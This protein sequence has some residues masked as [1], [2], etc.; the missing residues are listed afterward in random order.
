MERIS[1]TRVFRNAF[2]RAYGVALYFRSTKE[3]R[4]LVSLPCSKNR[5][6]SIKWVTPSRLELL[7]ALVGAWLL[8]YFS[9]VTGYD[10]ARST[11]W[12]D[13][14]VALSWIRSAPNRWKMFV[15]NRITA[16]E[17]RNSPT[18]CRH[19]PGRENPADHLSRGI[20]CS[21]ILLL[22]IWWQWPQWLGKQEGCWPSGN[23]ATT[24]SL[25]EG[26][27]RYPRHVLR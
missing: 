5:L 7:A 23:F 12:T 18:Q 26:K 13:T 20:L 14:T 4:T 1:Q 2:E 3:E 22:D 9:E 8:S 16:F 15:C 21:Q 11:L 19:C 10:T 17:S 25:P 24:K 27:R 6:D